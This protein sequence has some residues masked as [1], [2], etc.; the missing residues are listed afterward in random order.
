[1]DCSPPVSSVQVI[2]QAR[3]LEWAAI[4]F[5][6]GSSQP[7][8][9]TWISC[10]AGRFFTGWDTREGKHQKK[11][12]FF[13]AWTIS[14]MYQSTAWWILSTPVPGAKRGRD[15][16]TNINGYGRARFW[17]RNTIAH[18]EV[19]FLRGYEHLSCPRQ[20]PHGDGFT[21]REG[22]LEGCSRGLTKDKAQ[23]MLHPP[24]SQSLSILLSH[25][26]ISLPKPPPSIRT[27][28]WLPTLGPLPS[29]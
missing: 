13:S 22:D 21:G 12:W 25:R 16:Q 23:E 28:T 11:S 1:M 9:R 29:V 2:F 19:L 3:I 24:S 26:R 18:R 27:P 6:R 4:S 17:L 10:F 20:C 14:Y 8:D 15:Y 5:S 7:R